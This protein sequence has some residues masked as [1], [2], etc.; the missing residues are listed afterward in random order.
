MDNPQ[1]FMAAL[2]RFRGRFSI[3]TAKHQQGDTPALEASRSA[4]ARLATAESRL[5]SPYIV[6]F[7][8]R[9]Q[10]FAASSAMEEIECARADQAKL[11]YSE[12][13]AIGE[14]PARHQG[15]IVNNDGYTQRRM[16]AQ[17]KV[18]TRY[19]TDPE[20]REDFFAKI[21]K[22]QQHQVASV[23]A[24]DYA[25]QAE[26]ARTDD[27]LER[28]EW[29]TAREGE[30][31]YRA[32]GYRLRDAGQQQDY[33]RHRGH[34]F[35]VEGET[36][37]ARELAFTHDH[38]FALENERA[39]ER[40]AEFAARQEAVKGRFDAQGFDA[41]AQGAEVNGFA[42]AGE[43]AKPLQADVPLEKMGQGVDFTP[44]APRQMAEQTRQQ[45][46]RQQ[47]AAQRAPERQ[48]E[49]ARQ[50][51][52]QQQPRGPAPD[53]SKVRL[54]S[55]FSHSE[56]RAM[57]KHAR[58]QAQ[59]KAEPRY[60]TD[61]WRAQRSKEFLE[62]PYQR[63][64]NHWQD[65]GYKA[66][67]DL[68]NKR[69]VVRDREGQPMLID[70]GSIG[71][72]YRANDPEVAKL[73]ME[74]MRERGHESVEY[75]PAAS[76]T[77]EHTKETLA[78]ADRQGMEVSNRQDVERVAGIERQVDVHKWRAGEEREAKPASGTAAQNQVE[79]EGTVGSNDEQK[80]GVAVG[81]V[82]D[83][84]QSSFVA[85]D[86]ADEQPEKVQGTDTVQQEELAEDF[87]PRSLSDVEQMVANANEAAEK[88]QR[89]RETL[90]PDL[91]TLTAEEKE[92]YFLKVDDYEECIIQASINHS[93]G[94]QQDHG[95]DLDAMSADARREMW[96]RNLESYTV[97]YLGSE[98][99]AAVLHLEE[100][101]LSPEHKAGLRQ[102]Q[103]R[104]ASERWAK[105]EDDRAKDLTAREQGTADHLELDI[106]AE[107]EAAARSLGAPEK[108]ELP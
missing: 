15:A 10:M 48:P 35:D 41:K 60:G 25:R 86:A 56:L 42:A 19:A 44:A 22:D 62:Q 28:A 92:A 36:D 78:L 11:T 98:H 82:E 45:E 24:A 46:Q 37:R 3:P 64:V 105:W 84:A 13:L 30:L 12:R 17:A 2:E 91:D 4:P 103:E 50:Q 68:A 31:A 38:A 83:R 26:Q 7:D 21:P 67:V 33:E 95:M 40:T 43:A 89:L 49:Q 106:D 58:Q 63:Q 66:E 96:R 73:A 57:Q 94:L 100:H 104:W 47:H 5:R 93:E 51:D 69:V 16:M 54:E 90:Q 101:G 23:M 76:T 80:I 70:Q 29:L 85:K 6:E 99:A 39:K 102:A 9:R 34:R 27:M 1:N 55:I 108:R 81:V 72:R 59:D 87:E 52:Q 53:H 61:E 18:A 71:V 75:R 8:R 97:S 20:K 65:K 79:D 32:E 14:M 74:T 77:R 88:H 107:L